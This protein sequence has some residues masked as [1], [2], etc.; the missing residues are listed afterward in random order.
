MMEK[1]LKEFQRK[2]GSA[3]LVPGGKGAFEVSLGG[4]LIFSKLDKGR[5]PAIQELRDF[6]KAVA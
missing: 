2:F 1:L 6:V 5:F 3:K 4:E